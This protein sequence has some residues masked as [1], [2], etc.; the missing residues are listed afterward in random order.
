MEHKYPSV[1][2]QD[3]KQL[4]K[5]LK[6]RGEEKSENVMVNAL[7]REIQKNLRKIYIQQ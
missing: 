6:V 7:D 2:F 1:I 5:G 4:K 3:V